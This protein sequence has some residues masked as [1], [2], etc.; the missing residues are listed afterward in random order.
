ML[1]KQQADRRPFFLNYLSGNPTSSCSIGVL[2]PE[3]PGSG[4]AVKLTKQLLVLKAVNVA[5]LQGL[6]LGPGAV[7]PH[8]AVK[9]ALLPWG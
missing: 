7:N 2:L 6:P 3:V 1:I 4:Q 5:G 8:D 9:I